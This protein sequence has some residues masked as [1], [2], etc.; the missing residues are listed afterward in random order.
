M[1]LC[2]GFI[3]KCLNRCKHI[4]SYVASIFR[5]CDHLLV[6][7]LFDVCLCNVATIDKQACLSL[8]TTM[9]DVKLQVI[10]LS[11]VSLRKLRLV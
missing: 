10:K 7:S 5:E 6:S 3:V 8:S 11:C 9:F 2:A 4:V 1:S